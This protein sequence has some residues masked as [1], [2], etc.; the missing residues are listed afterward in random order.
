MGGLGKTTLVKEVGKSAKEFQLFDQVLM[1]VVSQTPDLRK[2]QGQLGGMF[3]QK[4]REETEDGR[5]DECMQNLSTRKG[6]V[7]YQM[8]FGQAL[9][10][11]I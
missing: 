2:I 6:S 11:Q 4:F 3:G 1:A 8:T 9:S 10:S 7:L 5:A